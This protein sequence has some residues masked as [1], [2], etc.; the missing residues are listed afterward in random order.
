MPLE[1]L[2]GSLHAHHR[3]CLHLRRSAER[4]D[5]NPVGGEV[6]HHGVEPRGHDVREGPAHRERR[7]ETAEVDDPQRGGRLAGGSQD[8]RGLG[9]C[10]RAVAEAHHVVGLGVAARLGGVPPGLVVEGRDPA[11][12]LGG[13]RQARPHELAG[14]QDPIAKARVGVGLRE[15]RHLSPQP[16]VGAAEAGQ[17]RVGPPSGSILV[18]VTV[19]ERL[20]TARP[21]AS[22]DL[23][24]HH[25]PHEADGG[26]MARRVE[27]SRVGQRV[28]V[29]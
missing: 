23:G 25:V 17:R 18:E 28:P 7:L 21:E 20:V 12:V 16:P 9:E 13:E 29:V 5:D 22:G 26:G 8:H 6:G 11:A 15:N 14:G 19:E 10:R 1:G 27:G 24:Q 2:F 4:L 3:V